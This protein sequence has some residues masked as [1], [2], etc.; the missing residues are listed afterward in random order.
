M[1]A[2][3]WASCRWAARDSRVG[4]RQHRGDHGVLI[5]VQDRPRIVSQ[6]VVIASACR[7]GNALDEADRGEHFDGR[8]SRRCSR[9]SVAEFTHR[10]GGL[11][12]E[13]QG[14]QDT[15]G[16]AL[17]TMCAEHQCELLGGLLWILWVVTVS[18]RVLQ[19]FLKIQ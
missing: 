1:R 12:G 19:R 6:P 16:H 18:G 3:R 17:Q 2:V 7:Y 13:Q 11:L 8:R 5:G 4:G 14:G 10:H 15:G 9:A